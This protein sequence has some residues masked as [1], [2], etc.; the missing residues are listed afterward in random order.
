MIEPL[1]DAEIPWHGRPMT[2]AAAPLLRDTL[3]DLR[4]FVRRFVVVTDDQAIAL[5]LWIA[6]THVIDAFDCTPYL[7]ITSATKRAGKTRLLEVLEPL[8]AR[9]WLTQRVSAAALVRKID[10]EHPTLLLDESDA[11]FK[12]E[13][14]Y[15][16]ALRG[17]QEG[18]A[19]GKLGRRYAAMV[20]RGIG[21][22]IPGIDPKPAEA[23][24][25]AV[26]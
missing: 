21:P 10:K 16:E 15:A 9:P 6:H 8:V 13:K 24:H 11:A 12:G 5:A 23:I 20:D 17:Y 4:A 7:Q 19:A 2:A 14:D 26:L 18:E 25:R 1:T 22:L 3:Q